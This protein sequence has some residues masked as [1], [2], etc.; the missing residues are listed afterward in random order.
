MLNKNAG[1][2]TE[3]LN[4]AGCS[5]QMLFICKMEAK[6]NGFD[7]NLK[8]SDHLYNVEKDIIDLK[9]NLTLLQELFTTESPIKTTQ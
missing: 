5:R 9:M 4:D 6:K 8:L 1:S 7:R 2:D 3:K